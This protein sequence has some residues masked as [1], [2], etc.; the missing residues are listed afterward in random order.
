MDFLRL[1]INDAGKHK[2]QTA[3]GVFLLEP[4]SVIQRSSM[5]V[6]YKTMGAGL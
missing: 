2:G 3:T 5:A 4:V 6:F 1:P